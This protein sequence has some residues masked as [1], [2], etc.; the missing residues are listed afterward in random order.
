MPSHRLK[1]KHI[2]PITL[3]ISKNREPCPPQF[4]DIRRSPAI[5]R[6][7][8]DIPKQFS[9]DM[10]IDVTT[11]DDQPPERAHPDAPVPTM[12]DINNW[13]Q[14]LYAHHSMGAC[15]RVFRAKISDYVERI[16]KRHRFA[17]LVSE[18]ILGKGVKVPKSSTALEPKRETQSHTVDSG[19]TKSEGP[20]DAAYAK[21]SNPVPVLHGVDCPK[22]KG[23]GNSTAKSE[24]DK[25][26]NRLERFKNVN[27]YNFRPQKGVAVVGVCETLEK[28]YLRLTAEP[29]PATVRPE[30]VLRRAFRHVFDTFMRTS[31]YRYIE[32]QFRSIRQDIQVQHLRSPF[33]VKLYAT[34]ARVALVHGDLDQFNQCQT[35]LRHLHR[36]VEG[37]P[38]Y[39]KEF[40]C[41][42]LLY[43]ALQNMQMDVLRYLQS[44]ENEAT[45]TSP[46]FFTPLLFKMF[47]PR[48]RMN[49]L[50]AMSSTA[51][52]LSLGT[53]KEALRFNTM[54]ECESF[55]R[56]AL[57]F[58]GGKDN[59]A[60]VYS[61]CYADDS[62][63]IV[64]S[65]KTDSEIERLRSTYGDIQTTLLGLHKGPATTGFEVTQMSWKYEI[66]SVTRENT[67]VDSGYFVVEES[68]EYVQVTGSVK[69]GSPAASKHKG[70]TPSS[71][72][73]NITLLKKPKNNLNQI[74]VARQYVLAADN[75]TAVSYEGTD[76][77]HEP[78]VAIVG[79]AN[80][81]KSSIFNRI[82][83]KFHRGSIVSDVP[84]TTRDRQYALA[85]WEGRSFRLIDTGGLEDD[86]MY[87]D[88]IKAQVERSLEDAHVA[89]VVVDGQ[90]GL[91]DAD[92]EVRDFVINATKRNSSLRILL[93]VNKCESFHFGDVLAEQFWRLGLGRPYP[94]S[95]LHGTGLAE[96]LDDCVS[97]FDQCSI[98]DH[99]D[100]V[101]SFIGRPNCGKSSLVNL[102][103]GTDR[104]LVSPSEGTTLDT[105][106]IPIVRGE[107]RFLLIDTAGMRLQTK[108]RRSFLPK[109]RSLRAIR[110]SDVCVLVVDAS[111]GISR[112]D[113]KMAEE[114]GLESRA[115]V[116]V[117]NKWDLV[118]KDPTV[119]KNALSYLKEKLHPVNYADVVFT[120]AKSGQRVTNILEACANAHD[121][122]SKN[123]STALL[124][125]I[126]REA[127]FLQKPPVTHGKRL[128]IY[129]ACQVHN[130]PPGIALF[131]N[132][133]Q[134]LTKDYAEYLEVFFRRSL[135]LT[136]SPIKWYP[137]AKRRRHFIPDLRNRRSSSRYSSKELLSL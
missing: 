40:D 44:L 77:P 21:K 95:A 90:V 137:R 35:Q 61:V 78:I 33:V 129:Y 58:A 124:N 72:G 54:G 85:D 60:V 84:G 97:D 103:T 135:N 87:G 62:K 107:Q 30:P 130:K 123:F 32:E 91:T 22:L 110:K 57:E 36:R 6:V 34:N 66:E 5:A 48:F 99:N 105:V 71:D 11:E 88:S 113:V 15:S 93:C 112:N 106:E 27:A 10:A 127:T 16:V 92:M 81:G 122:F 67:Y 86:S 98:E 134:L 7:P 104:C 43:L 108:D 13:I 96:L 49:A 18:E 114:I 8:G 46:P 126:L 119:Y 45:V 111:W 17:T 29:N 64:L 2:I 9:S 83:K 116:I 55:I 82:S 20:G 52:S 115:A 19:E 4:D 1:A 59:I 121:Q 117:C 94:V 39:Q 37:F 26:Q 63:N 102:L 65:H 50:V 51:M 118:D 24:G 41:Y 79:R 100:V 68:D 38:L 80:V 23:P 3:K 133:E 101:I 74:R 69:S 136:G 25:K 42:F 125:D 31:N 47:E 75:A 70:S 73:K 53:I 14:R 56:A 128:N 109:G 131:C 89:I 76:P 132:D 12:D 120:S 28:P